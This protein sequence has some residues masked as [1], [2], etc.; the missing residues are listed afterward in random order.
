MESEIADIIRK[1]GWYVADVF[2]GE[3]PFL[4]TIGLMRTWDHPEFILFGLDS[5][6]A[7]QILSAL[8]V[9]IRAGR[10]YR[11][12]GAYSG[13]LQGD[14]QV[15]IRPVHPTRH[16]LYLGYAMGYLRSIGRIGDL[17]AVQ[18]FWPDRTGQFPYE[19]GCDVN[20]VCCQPRLDLAL[21]AAEIAEFER[22]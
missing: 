16:P 5:K 15:G 2:D 14:F 12:P 19:V 6:T 17:E 3:P 22:K 8:V 4:Y 11:G 10:S 13:V 20:V 21:T 1:H 18:V 7:H 9:S